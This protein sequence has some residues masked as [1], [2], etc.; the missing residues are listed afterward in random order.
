MTW[1][2]VS[3]RLFAVQHH[4][5]PGVTLHE[6]ARREGGFVQQFDMAEALHEL[7]PQ[8]LQL[9]FRQPVAHAAMDPKPE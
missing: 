1:R 4:R 5:H 3:Q 6:A 8:N 2:G 7:L 9:E